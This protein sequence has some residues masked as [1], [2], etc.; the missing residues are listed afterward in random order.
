MQPKEARKIIT[1][2]LESGCTI[3]ETTSKVVGHKTIIVAP[4]GALATITASK[5]NFRT[6]KTYVKWAKKH[7][8]SL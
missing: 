2:L 3:Q 7:G 5:N 8:A 6:L 1:V 4:D